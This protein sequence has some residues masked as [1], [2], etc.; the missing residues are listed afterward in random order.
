MTQV[1][2]S[3]SDDIVGIAQNLDLRDVTDKS[4]VQ[5]EGVGD[6]EQ[7]QFDFGHY[8]NGGRDGATEVPEIEPEENS[9]ED[10][11]IV[12][13]E[14]NV[15]NDVLSD[16]DG[17]AGSD[18]FADIDDSDEEEPRRRPQRRR[19]PPVILSY[20]EIGQPSYSYRQDR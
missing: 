20:E 14:E 10:P 7:L 17:T 4:D 3:D 15:E 8:E 9:Q 11:T 18:T 1:S 6:P 2:E 5:P 13:T 19:L 12:A 16:A